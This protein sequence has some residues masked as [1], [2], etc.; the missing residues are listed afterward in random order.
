[1]TMERYDAN[2][3]KAIAIVESLRAGIPTRLSTRELPDLRA[4]LTDIIRK[5]LTQFARGKSRKVDLPGALTD[6]AKLMH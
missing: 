6:R 5:D 3:R 2:R 1:M 4:S